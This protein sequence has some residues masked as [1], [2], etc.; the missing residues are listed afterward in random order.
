MKKKAGRPKAG[1][2]GLSKRVIIDTAMALVDEKGI[3]AFS[4]RQLASRLGVNP[5]AVYHHLKNKQA[6]LDELVKKAIDFSGFERDVL[7]G[8]SDYNWKKAV[9][10]FSR[11]Y[12]GL[13]RAHRDLLLYL[14]ANPSSGMES[15]QSG[16]E[17]LY[18]ILRA[19][20]LSPESI[21]KAADIIIDYLNGYALADSTG[22]IPDNE[23][24]KFQLQQWLDDPKTADY[25]VLQE[26][27]QSINGDI[28]TDPELGLDCILAGIDSTL[29]TE[30]K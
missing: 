12:L 22:R 2:S 30:S 19:G 9:K 21:I 16:N 18:S 4:M 14:T 11:Y 6:V 17:I 25:P 15:V 20:G 27:L 5:M 3:E 1:R 8:T 13:F 28:A 24:R 10:I 7:S 23:Q 26:V 29:E